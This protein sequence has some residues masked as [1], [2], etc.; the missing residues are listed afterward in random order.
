MHF[1]SRCRAAPPAI[2]RRTICDPRPSD[3]PARGSCAC[4]PR[5]PHA[6]AP[7]T[8]PIALVL[9]RGWTPTAPGAAAL[10]DAALVLTADHELNP[11]TFA[12]RCVASTGATPYAVV[13]AGLAALQGYRHGGATDRVEALFDEVER[14]RRA[15][16][17]IAARLRRGELIPGFGHPLY[18]DGDPRAR[19]L[20]ELIDEVHPRAAG[21]I[22]ARA[23]G[24]TVTC[25]LCEATC[26]LEVSTRDG[27]VVEIRGDRDDV[28][29]HGF[30][31]PKGFD[32][33]AAARG[34][35]SRAHAARQARRP[36]R[37]GEL[38]RGLRRDRAAGSGRCVAGPRARRGRRLRRQPQR[39]QPRRPDLRPGA[40]A[41]LGT[42]NVFS[43][44]TVDQMPKQVSAGLMFGTGLSVPVPDID[45]TDYLLMLGANPLASNGSLLTAP[46]MRGRLRAIRARGGK[47]VVVDPR[48]SRTAEEAD[49][50]LFIRPGTD[51]HFLFAIV[52]T[53]L[54][55]GPRRPGPLR[56][57]PP[58]STT[59][60][61][62]APSSRR[63]V[64]APRAASAAD[65]IRRIARE[66]RRGAARRR[67]RPHRHLHAGVRHARE[68]A[69]RR[70]ERAHRQPRP[71][72]RRDVRQGRGRRAQHRDAPGGRGRGVRFG[73]WKSRV[74]GLPEVYGELPVAALAE[75]IDTPGDGRSAR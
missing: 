33:Q 50:H 28:F 6:N 15:R 14:P 17:T 29:S 60:S 63:S 13:G 31:C 11:S 23:L 43:A 20:L 8:E 67:V 25:P 49:E 5:S 34:S 10:F 41:A 51:A 40:A 3:A 9:Q 72:G 16:E 7:S 19:T 46:D 21:T 55:R 59:S 37:R 32:A 54:R 42:R 18:P 47:L 26:G 64:V 68:L 53:L 73:R 74:R 61:A 36:L 56:A 22:L 39:P 71:R 35:R 48:R 2:P 38:G 27:E 75:E 44:S 4:S 69:R 58:A 52:H 62:R 45:R 30:I 70:R 12:A 24:E 66:L 57:R 65:T 1:S